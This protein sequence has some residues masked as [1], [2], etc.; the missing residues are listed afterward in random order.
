MLKEMESMGGGGLGMLNRNLSDYLF[1]I[2][3][4]CLSCGAGVYTEKLLKGK[5][6]ASTNLQ[7]IFM[8]VNGM[9]V[10]F[11]LMAYK[12]SG[13]SSAD[14]ISIVSNPVSVGLVINAALAG[15][16]T[17]HLLRTLGS[18]HK[19]IAAAIEIPLIA[20]CSLFLFDYSIS[21]WTVAAILLVSSGVVL[22]SYQPIPPSKN[23]EQ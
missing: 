5:S 14:M 8:Y 13:A 19:S 11:G 23:K 22:Y 20:V 1:I 21:L 7:N 9:I 2:A 6:E 12:G 3:Q 15:V 18:I 4:L 10:N 16:V 17:G